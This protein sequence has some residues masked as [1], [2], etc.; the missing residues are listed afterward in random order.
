MLRAL[1]IGC[2]DRAEVDLG[3]LK[4]ISEADDGM[5]FATSVVS[6]LILLVLLIFADLSEFS[7]YDDLYDIS[8]TKNRIRCSHTVSEACERVACIDSGHPCN[9]KLW[10]PK[11]MLGH[12]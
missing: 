1:R 3:P 7:M 10:L 5:A 9:A 6:L 4:V 11:S 8:S 2:R 12:S